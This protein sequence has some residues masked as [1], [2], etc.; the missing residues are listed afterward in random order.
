MILSQ[1]PP[2]LP[3]QP[4]SELVWDHHPETHSGITRDGSWLLA[5]AARTPQGHPG[6]SPLF[7][8]G[9]MSHSFGY[10]TRCL[11]EHKAVW[12]ARPGV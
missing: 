2:G 5:Y 8:A 11:L 12:K 1:H 3:W 4:E 10:Y 9:Q 6:E 7:Q